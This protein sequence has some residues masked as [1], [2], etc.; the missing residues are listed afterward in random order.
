MKRL[1]LR[2]VYVVAYYSGIFNLLIYFGKRP[3]I[4][5]YHNVIEDHLYDGVVHL[6]LTHKASVFDRQLAIIKKKFPIT[7]DLTPGEVLIT[8]DDG[9]RNN[10]SVVLPIMQ[11]HAVTATFFI[12]A[13]YFDNIEVLWCDRFL[14][15]LAHV[16]A[17]KFEVVG[18]RISTHSVADRK[19][20]QDALWQWLLKN[21][22]SKD[23]LLDAMEQAY[24]FTRLELNPDF[25]DQRYKALSDVEIS[26]LSGAGCRTACHSYKHDILSKLTDIQLEDDFQRCIEHRGRYNSDWYSYP[27]GRP[28]EV[29]IRV[30][31]KCRESGYSMAFINTDASSDH[32]FGLSRINMPDTDD[33]I[34]IYAKLSGFEALLKS[35]VGR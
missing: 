16:P 12:P 23:T 3:I 13:G 30:V 17:G 4:I 15:W 5:T 8:F 18:Q 25:R 24:S 34:L 11:R 20:A 28:Q 19:I 14:M 26:A 27:F 1:I 6:S 7:D 35:M 32:K 33:K 21:Y 31:D 10:F 9:Y 29:D 2:L 22:A